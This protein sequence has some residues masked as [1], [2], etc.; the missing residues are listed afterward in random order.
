MLLKVFHRAG[1]IETH[2]ENNSFF[3]FGLLM[4]VVDNKIN[5]EYRQFYPLNVEFYCK[6]I[7]RYSFMVNH[8]YSVQ[9]CYRSKPLKV[10]LYNIFSHTSGVAKG[11]EILVDPPLWSSWKC[12]SGLPYFFRN[13][14]YSGDGS[15][16]RSDPLP[17]EPP[18]GWR[19]WFLM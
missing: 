12:L 13:S 10:I 19:L 3:A 16:W 5:N 17:V 9:Q 2:W 11:V 18:W 15:C 7:K 14:W 8:S 4:N 1:N 6:E